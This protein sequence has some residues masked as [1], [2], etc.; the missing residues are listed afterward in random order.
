ME[1]GTF[2]GKALF[3]QRVKLAAEKAAVTDPSWSG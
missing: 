1:I 2:A 3:T